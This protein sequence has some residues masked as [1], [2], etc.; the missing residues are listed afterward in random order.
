VSDL[1]D[2][3]PLAELQAASLRTASRSQLS[4][5]PPDDAMDAAAL[6]AFLS[7]HRYGVMATGDADGNPHARPV[8]Y[9]V[10]RGVFLVATVSGARLRQVR[11]RPQA[12]LVVTA[13]D[14]DDHRVISV[15]GDVVIHEGDAF[16]ARFAPVAERWRARHGQEPGWAVALLELVPRRVYS[17]AAPPSGG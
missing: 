5:H 11:A 16:A 17:Y 13:G 6:Q 8:A 12:S 4:S 3:A 14:G 2:Y 15:D 7:A 1:A 9:L 10:D